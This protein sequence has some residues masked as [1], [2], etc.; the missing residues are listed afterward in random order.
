MSRRWLAIIP[1]IMLI[2]GACNNGGCLENGTTLPLAGLYS[3]SSQSTI[4]VDS[5]E[6]WGVGAPGDSILLKPSRATSSIYL[7]FRA[8]HDFVEYTFGFKSS[9]LN[10]AALYDTITFYY[11]SIPYFA[12]A[13]C[14]AMYIY[15]L[16]NLQ[17]TNHLIDS[18]GITDSLFTNVD[19]E[20]IKIYYR[21]R[22]DADL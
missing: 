9:G 10:I 19:R 21:T 22:E 2:L 3:S 8:N 18:V 6:V 11:E 17:H 20:Q 4:S 14:G 15:R 12:S 13:S 7:P 1:L 16:T 5:L